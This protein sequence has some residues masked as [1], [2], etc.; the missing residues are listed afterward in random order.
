MSCTSIFNHWKK[1]KFNNLIVDQFVVDSF[2]DL[3]FRKLG[4]ILREEFFDFSLFLFFS[5]HMKI[6]GIIY[7]HSELKIILNEII[8]SYVIWNIIFFQY[9]VHDIIEY[10]VKINLYIFY[11]ILI[12]KWKRKSIHENNFHFH[13]SQS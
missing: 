3:V 5:S 2:K 8:Y 13:F 12:D 11:A 1:E 7:F 10:R 6:L 4:R 9:K